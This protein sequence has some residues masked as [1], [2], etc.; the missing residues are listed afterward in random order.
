MK[1]ADIDEPDFL[2]TILDS[3]RPAVDRLN[4]YL[5]RAT[6]ID[7]L[8]YRNGEETLFT[9]KKTLK[10]V[11]Y[12]LNCDA[13]TLIERWDIAKG[14][15]PTMRP[16][17]PKL[18]P[19]SKVI[20]SRQQHPKPIPNLPS[21]LQQL[22]REQQPLQQPSVLELA[23]NPSL[24]APTSR[25]LH[26]P[27]T[28]LTLTIPADPA[29]LPLALEQRSAQAAAPVSR[30]TITAEHSAPAVATTSPSTGVQQPCMLC[31]KVS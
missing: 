24:L 12:L 9:R 26:S 17:Q 4:H 22:E 30:S 23:A 8:L 21:S 20:Q 18:K 28:G 3:T 25:G 7:D 16:P 31:M 13:V 27:S 19:T 6:V 10:E 15:P 11:D 5:Q 2:D 1:N 14:A 29:I